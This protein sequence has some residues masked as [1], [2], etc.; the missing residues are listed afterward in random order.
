L[1]QPDT[2]TPLFKGLSL[3]GW[4]QFD[5]VELSFHPRLT[6]LTGANAAGK[7]TLLSLLASHF[8]WQA[9]FVGTPARRK[10]GGTRSFF[11][12]FWRRDR[13][14]KE[15]QVG[16]VT[17]TNGAQ[18]VLQV[19][20][21]MGGAA[22]QVAIAGQQPVQ[23]LFIPSHRPTF[24]YQP[25]AQI[26]TTPPV[27]Q[28]LFDQY[29]NEFRTRFY[30]PSGSQ[31][32]PAYRLKEA[33]ISLAVFGEGNNTVEPNP[34]AF[35]LYRGFIDILRAVLPP[36]MGFETLSVRMP[37]VVMETTS[38]DFSIDAVSGGVAAIIDLA[39]QIFM[40]GVDTADFAVVIDEPENHLHPELQR[41][42]L[43]GFLEAFPAT[44]FIVATHNPFMVGSVADSH[45]YALRYRGADASVESSSQLNQRR[46]SSVALDE[47]NKAGSSDEILEEVLGL[48]GTRALWVERRLREI[49]QKYETHSLDE[50]LLRQLHEDFSRLGMADVFPA[51]AERL[52]N[53]D[54]TP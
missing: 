17:Y 7:T 3:G 39:F 34:E 19:P 24:V 29:V 9:Q 23:G 12:G 41:S 49:L 11:S 54:Q 47:A 1:H 25:V 32:T 27:R 48:P 26:P 5:E 45:V 30:S 2:S 6:V 13:D 42:L 15:E 46:V 40:R 36:T 50:N 35:D 51:N 33:L 22:F 14:P 20:A 21:E 53:R 8:G 18:A 31:F 37:E 10:I 44:Q 38:G 43:P 28:Q 52:V 4:R 16:L